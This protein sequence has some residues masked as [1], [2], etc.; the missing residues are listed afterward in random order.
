MDAQSYRIQTKAL[1]RVIG[2]RRA[3]RSRR[4]W[5]AWID[6][7]FLDSKETLLRYQL[8]LALV[9]ASLAVACG[10][11]SS[12]SASPSL[13][14]DAQKASYAIG[15][16]IGGS[17]RPAAD[18]IDLDAFRQGV[19]DALAE[20]EPALPEGEL[21]EALQRFSTQIQQAQVDERL[22]LATK[23]REAGEAYLAANAAKEGVTTTP[24]G[25]QYEVLT[26]GTGPKATAESEVTVHYRGTLVD[27][28]E[29]DSSIGGEPATF[30]V[31]GVIPGFSEGLM[32]MPR[33]SKSRLVIPGALG[34]G[35]QGTG[36]AV[37]PDATL[38]FEVEL[39]E[40][41]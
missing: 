24:S 5:W 19:E 38:I 41:R 28:T 40:V 39:L 12:S 4:E 18:Q 21:Q 29:F 26:E 1:Q 11:S 27:G 17:L 6:S 23:N 16:D 34:Y 32:L 25:L 30:P 9:G 37:G 14:S 36:G 35:P 2:T 13:E 33:G 3:G 7:L 31:S 20:R 10:T 22:A 15:R 8:G